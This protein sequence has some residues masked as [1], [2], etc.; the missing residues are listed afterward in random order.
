MNKKYLIASDLDGTLLNTNH[1]ISDNNLAAIKNF[2]SLGN[3]FVINT[4]RP[5]FRT[6]DC[7]K[8]LNQDNEHHYC[9][10]YNG[11]L[12]LKG[13]GEVVYKH[14]LKNNEVKE[15]VELAER[16]DDI[17]TLMYNDSAIY[18]DKLTPSTMFL[19]ALNC[20]IEIKNGKKEFKN[21]QNIF[22]ILFVGEKDQIEKAKKM[23]PQAYFDKYNIV[24]SGPLWLEIQ[25]KRIDKG[26]GLKTLCDL[27]KIDYQNA[28]AVGDEE[29]DLSM[30]DNIFNGVAVAN[31]RPLVLSKANFIVKSNDEDGIKDLINKL[32]G[33]NHA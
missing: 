8:R 23:I 18:Y 3:Y 33:D 13:N 29:N 31:A 12:I 22:K 14:I 26:T 21:Y 24:Q 32:I 16:L 17:P 7:L 2:T 6:I 9:I 20:T 28:Y 11:A 25:S 27:L 19:E 1:E 30:I 4:G 10:C 15:I 5:Y